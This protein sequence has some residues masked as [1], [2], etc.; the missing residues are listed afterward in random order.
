MSD[1]DKIKG[2][3]AFYNEVLPLEEELEAARLVKK[4]DPER[5]FEAKQAFEEKRRAYRQLAQGITPSEGEIVAP[6]IKAS[7]KA[8]SVGG[9][10]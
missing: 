6:E 7:A 10:D 2:D 5:W 4:E 8:A 1:L 9:K 3:L